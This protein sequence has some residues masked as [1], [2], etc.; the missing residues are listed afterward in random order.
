MTQLLD[1]CG[2]LQSE[3]GDV[4]GEGGPVDCIWELGGGAPVGACSPVDE[5][6]KL[7]PSSGPW[8]RVLA[9]GGG[10]WALGAG[11]G[12][13]GRVLGP[14]SGCWALGADTGYWGRV[15][16][17]GGGDWA[18]GAGASNGR[19]IW[20][21]VQALG[22]GGGNGCWALGAGTGPWERVQ[23]Q[24]AGAGS[25][26]RVQALRAGAGPWERVLGFGS[27]C[28]ALGAGA[29][30]GRGCWIT[31]AGAG[32]ESGCWAQG[33][34]A[35]PGSGC[36][37]RVLGTGAGPWERVL[38]TGAG[39]SQRV[40]G[41][42]SGDNNIDSL[43]SSIKREFINIADGVTDGIFN[44]LAAFLNHPQQMKEPSTHSELRE[45]MKQRKNEKERIKRVKALFVQWCNLKEDDGRRDKYLERF[46]IVEVTQFQTPYPPPSH[47]VYESE[48]IH[49]IWHDHLQLGKPKDK[50]LKVPPMLLLE[51]QYL[52]LDVAEDQNII[53]V[54]SETKEIVGLVA[55]NWIAE[56]SKGTLDWVNGIIMKECEIRK[57][58]RLE[59]TGKICQMGY[60]AGSRSKAGFD[61]VRNI[62]S[63]KNRLEDFE[64]LGSYI[65]ALFWNMCKARLPKPIIDDITGFCNSTLVPRMNYAAKDR[66]NS[67]ILGNYT[68]RVGDDDIEFDCVPM[69]PPSGFM[70]YNYSRGTHNEKCPHKYAVF[71]TTART[72]GSEEGGHFFIDDYGIRV[73]QSAN[74]VVV[75]KPTD[76]HGTTLSIK[77]PTDKESTANSHQIGMSIVTLIRL[78]K[79]WERYQ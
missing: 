68:V 26:E 76:F 28:W 55:R 64:H 47:C 33:A 5:N 15:L 40:L 51:Q 54:D 14:G 44:D 49:E 10:S 19:G 3:G 70:A 21:W 60:S 57:S 41:P 30:S 62:T 12:L 48:Q 45:E 42:R 73:R 25:R 17:F 24:G 16:G 63:Q 29:G 66:A 6:P 56:D 23:A 8:G 1:T 20:E 13:W 75:W 18:L 32:P 77:G 67:Q 38:G 7:A 36:W 71:W 31:G 22:A 53:F 72:Y 11:A 34:G 50:R 78:V 2:V 9:P 69:A 65:F 43:V 46:T 37:E 59:D 61:W 52:Q 39:P 79:L 74:C 35:G 4:E 58:V 27:G